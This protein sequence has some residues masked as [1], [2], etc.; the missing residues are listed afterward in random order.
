L[1]ITNAFKS[2]L[3]DI[4]IT[5]RSFPA[6]AKH[7]PTFYVPEYGY[8]KKRLTSFL[9]VF[10]TIFGAIHIAGWNLPFPTEAERKLWRIASI[11]VA[12]L[13]IA[14]LAVLFMVSY[15]ITLC[16]APP[17]L[18]KVLDYSTDP[19]LAYVVARLMLLGLAV[20]LLRH[21][22]PSAFIAVDWAK[23]YPHFL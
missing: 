9:L 5:S 8:S 17:N 22:P 23:F 10:A 21:Q 6:D 19:M 11:A 14:T 3:S 15:L 13:P 1:P 12:C 7:V 4:L 20:A 18:T 2:T 16:R